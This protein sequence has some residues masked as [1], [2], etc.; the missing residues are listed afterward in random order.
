MSLADA[1]SA[2]R[3]V[4]D[5]AAIRAN[6]QTL[7]RQAP[8][9][10][11][12]AVVKADAYG[13]G[14]ASVAAALFE[15]GCRDFFVAILDEGLRLRAALPP[16]ARIHVLNGLLPGSEGHCAQAGLIPVLNSLDQVARWRSQA[17]RSGHRLPAALQS[18]T[19]MG[20][21]GLSADESARLLAH[22]ALLEGL[23]IG[24]V[25]S[26]LVEAELPDSPL[27]ALQ[28]SRFQAFRAGWPG[29]RASLANSSGIF[30]GADYHFDLL[31]PG[32]AL[33]GIAP[34]AGRR[35]PLQPVLRLQAR[36]IQCR[37][38]AAG[39]SIGYNHTW[40]ASR[41]S[42]IATL[43]IGYADGYPRALGNR[44]SVAI[45]G[46]AAPVVGRVSMDTLTVDVTEVPRELMSPGAWFDLIDDIRDINQLAQWAEASAYELL[47][48]LGERFERI[49][50]G[51]DTP[52]ALRPEQAAAG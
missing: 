10:S 49:H 39:D 38:I 48:R 25:M 9:A 47:T 7:G 50:T 21:L 3:L 15:A 22:P 16:G 45:G 19:G 26:H 27:N 12:G 1:G 4:V 40:R 51:S 36:M 41:P 5:L 24:L 30:L 31:R 46:H 8:A 23:D 11:C 18:D 44:A 32:A 28:R 43:A 2:A 20:R 42:R 52:R 29:A 6:W 37:D 14:A 33:Y 35:N 17:Q 13:L 34:Q